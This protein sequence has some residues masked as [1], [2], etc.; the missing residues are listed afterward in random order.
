MD[1]YPPFWY[2]HLVTHVLYCVRQF[3]QGSG[4][5]NYS[6]LSSW[7]SWKTHVRGSL[8]QAGLSNHNL[9]QVLKLLKHTILAKFFNSVGLLFRLTN[10]HYWGHGKSL[11]Y[12][13]LD[14]PHGQRSLACCSP[15]GCEELD[16]TEQLRTVE[17]ALI[18]KNP[19]ANA[20]DTRD[21]GSIPGWEDPLIG[22]SNPLQYSC[23]ENSMDRE[24]WQAT[25]HGATESDM[26]ER[27]SKHNYYVITVIKITVANIYWI[28]AICHQNAAR[29][30]LTTTR[31]PYVVRIS[32]SFYW[33][34]HWG[35]ERV[36]NLSKFSWLVEDRAR[37]LPKA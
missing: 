1:N 13:C 11:Q 8:L 30:H 35:T 23:L 34:R 6:S 18:V 28:L 22:N 21:M 4:F 32:S 20:G 10:G 24:H 25:V 37:K 14:N 9:L 5:Q 27:L 3:H 26:T 7:T 36:R 15:R 17:M 2:L 16:M 31:S 29:P 12:S 19:L 33:W